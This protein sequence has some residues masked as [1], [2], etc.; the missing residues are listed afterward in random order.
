VASLIV[1]AVA[2][3]WWIENS[4]PQHVAAPAAVLVAPPNLISAPATIH[5]ELPTGQ[6]SAEQQT[7]AQ[8]PATPDSIDTLGG[9]LKAAKPQT[10]PEASTAM[11][12]QAL[13]TP[14]ALA[15]A[16]KPAAK[17][18]PHPKP[19]AKTA[20]EP[21]SDVTL[22]TALIAHLQGARAHKKTSDGVRAELKECHQMAI[23]PAGKCVAR[24]CAGVWKSETACA[25]EK[26]PAG[27]A[28]AP[29]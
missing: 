4:A 21:D 3:W 1:V 23:D 18:K 28:P 5:D 14:S 27:N 6:A 26:T 10:L 25:A 13:E 19:A 24:V 17:E 15:K 20:A 2:V 22:L 16:T 9:T 8:V 7:L 29:L 11:L 12:T